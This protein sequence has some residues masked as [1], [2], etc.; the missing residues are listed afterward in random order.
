MNT[1][2]KHCRNCGENKLLSEFYLQSRPPRNH[3]TICKECKK[4]R[5]NIA[6]SKNRAHYQAYH[7]KWQSSPEWKEYLSAYH[8]RNK[9]R[10]L[11]RDKERPDYL[12][13]KNIR[14]HKRRARLHGN[15]G[16][17]TL[18]E[19]DALKRRFD[20]RCVHCRKR[21]TL[22]KDHVKPLCKGGTNDIG[23]IQPLCQSCN[24]VKG[25]N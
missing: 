20:H 24:S 2:K 23:N 21:K 14:W 18:E 12:A 3:E 15:G 11:K 19:W 8:R 22:T 25:R 7:R 13:N 16:N 9:A 6:R 1:P 17:H 5:N 4:L 10:I